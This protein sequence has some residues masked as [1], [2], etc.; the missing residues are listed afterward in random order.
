MRGD[1]GSVTAEF[2]AALPAVVIVLVC[3]LAGIETTGQQVRLQDAAAIAARSLGRG[4]S[5]GTALGRARQLAPGVSLGTAADGD[6][7]CAVLRHRAAGPAG[8]LRLTLEARSCSLGDG[9]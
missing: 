2:A 7:V 4:E 6:L 3:C 5:A 1:R 8:L 9:Q